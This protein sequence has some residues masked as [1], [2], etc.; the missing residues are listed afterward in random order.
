MNNIGNTLILPNF[1]N[2][3]LEN[4]MVCKS[5][6]IKGGIDFQHREGSKTGNLIKI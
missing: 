1:G 4:D 3:F 6:D 5:C 2:L